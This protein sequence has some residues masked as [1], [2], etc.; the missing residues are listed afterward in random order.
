MSWEP[1]SSLERERKIC[2]GLL[3][4]GEANKY[5]IVRQTALTV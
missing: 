3:I 5:S 1:H 2:R 4:Q